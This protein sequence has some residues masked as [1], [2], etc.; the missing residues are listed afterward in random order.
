MP[1]SNYFSKIFD[2]SIDDED[3]FD[4]EDEL[5]IDR[6]NILLSC[7]SLLDFATELSFDKMHLDFHYR[8]KHPYLID[9]SNYAF[10]NQRLKPLPN[11][12]DYSP[13]KYI[14]VNGT[15][16]DHTN[17]AEAETVLSIIENNI[18]RFPNGEYPT[19]GIATF[20]IAQRNLIKSKIIERRKFEKYA[21]FNDKIL[22]LEENG[23][24]VKNL[25]N[26][27]GDERD[28]IIL[29]TTYGYNK[30]GNF[31]HRFGP[32]NHKKGNKLLNVI[33]TRAKYKVYVCTSIP[34]ED[35]LNYKDYLITEGENNRRAV[36]FAY[37]A[38]SKAVSENDDESRFAVL[39]ALAEN[40]TNTN[41][42]PIL[43]AD[44][45]SPFEEE[46]YHALTQ[47]FDKDSI[48]PQ[49][50]FA[51]F[52][53]DMVYESKKE[54]VPKI[55]IECDGAAYHSSQEAYLYDRHRQKILEKHGFIFHRIF[56]TN[57]WRNTKRETKILVDF[58]YEI[59][60]RDVFNNPVQS[61]TALAFTDNISIIEKE[62]VKTSPSV[63]KE[64]KEVIEA[65]SENSQTELFQEK[66]GINSKVKVKYLNNGKDI[67]VHIVE[68]YVSQNVIQNGIQKI[69]QKSPLGVSLIGKC[70]GETV[71]VGNLDNYVE[72]MEIVN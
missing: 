27:Q 7:E 11:S 44:L 36:F 15:Y 32:I 43:N 10:Y 33:I 71:K 47:H 49:L 57:W 22:E 60:N 42:G 72:I 58:I 16:S 30:D 66:V 18:S 3:E 38:Y 29:S 55:A 5:I 31:A 8:S 67:N 56:S 64:L 2:G 23:F 70:V 68:N 19:I 1:P 65:V 51:G 4:E 17:D 52:R 35:F 26:I 34:E 28:V 46:V 25:E 50:Q 12:I 45:E 37:I 6:D 59:E 39:N 13:I 40:S 9:F 61:D 41:K 54:G 20:N 62:L 48:I 69:N 14:Q 24:F 53:I 21:E 63:Q